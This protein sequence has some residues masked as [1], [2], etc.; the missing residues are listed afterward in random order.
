MTRYGY[1]E[2]LPPTDLTTAVTCLW[3][4]R[5]GDPNV[6]YT[7]RVLPDGC[8]DLI[9]DGHRLFVAGADTGPVLIEQAPARTIVGI[10][11]APGHAPGLL[12]CPASEVRDR[13]V[14]LTELWSTTRAQ[15]LKDTLAAAPDARAAAERLAVAARQQLFAAPPHDRL[16]AALVA[17]LGKSV[18]CST[19]LV[20]RL[21]SELGVTERS[22]HR[23]CTQAI[24]Y[25]PKMLAR[26]IRFRK[27]QRMAR[28][29]RP[30]S[31]AALAAA[32]GFSDQAH[33]TRECRR[34]SGLTPTRLFGRT[35]P[36]VS[37]TFNTGL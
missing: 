10:R 8:I 6:V 5:V 26:V 7:D 29:R 28:S 16:V 33:L 2:W 17:G 37:E 9:W 22:L 12:G 23:R 32:A 36:I 30:L 24:G 3:R 14:D 18:H 13:R 4:G 11:A 25:G 27:A 34:L 19:G 15:A 35:E 21:A 31:L 20:A 1:A